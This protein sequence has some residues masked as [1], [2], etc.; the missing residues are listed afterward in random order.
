VWLSDSPLEVLLPSKI[1]PIRRIMK[2]IV[3]ALQNRI[4]CSNAIRSIASQID[5]FIGSLL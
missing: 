2:R 5:V 3:T 4:G 1:V